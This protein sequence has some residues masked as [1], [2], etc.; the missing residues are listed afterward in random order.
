MYF[1]LQLKRSNKIKKVNAVQKN[2]AAAKTRQ[3]WQAKVREKFEYKLKRAHMKH[4][5][6]QKVITYFHPGLFI[7]P[8]ARSLLQRPL[9]LN[10]GGTKPVINRRELII[11]WQ[12]A[13]VHTHTHQLERDLWCQ[14]TL[15]FNA[16][17]AAAVACPSGN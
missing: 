7:A 12:R 10:T 13:S 1:K 6:S 11:I 9:L 17:A 14:I 5:R 16:V 3:L 2:S 15:D 4:A 8:R